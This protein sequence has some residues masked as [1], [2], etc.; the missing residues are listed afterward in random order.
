MKSTQHRYQFHL[1]IP[2]IIIELI[3]HLPEIIL[4]KLT[5]FLLNYNM[6]ETYIYGFPHHKG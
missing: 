1:E 3:E 2:H 6:L 4:L 5:I